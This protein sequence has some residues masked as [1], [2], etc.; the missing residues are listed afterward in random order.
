MQYE[1]SSRTGVAA[2]FAAVVLSI[3]MWMTGC[4]ATTPAERSAESAGAAPHGSNGAAVA[5]GA[6]APQT[7]STAAAAAAMEAYTEAIPGT[8][9][10]FDMVPV[11]AGQVTIQTDDGPRTVD[12]GPFWIEKTETTWDAF[13][14]YAFLDTA[15]VVEGE[16]IIRPSKPY[17]APDRGFGHRGYA[18]LSMSYGVAMTYAQWLSLKTGHTYRIPT[19]A[20]WEYACRAGALE[21]PG[22]DKAGL[23][24]RAWYWDNALDK[25]HPV[26][27]LKPNAWGI[28][29]MLGN[30]LEWCTRQDGDVE[31]MPVACGG[32]YNSKADRVS[33]SARL[34]QTPAWQETDP[35][36]PKSLFWLTDATFIGF[37]VIRVP[38]GQ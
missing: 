32:H 31:A 34:Q 29:D 11:P 21:D 30:A 22:A 1:S 14:V 13:D 15:E 27:S 19:E 6:G 8:L 36:I 25:T 12:V 26:A 33:C 4:A 17:G 37:R 9:V 23:A 35:Q 3:G 38:D 24:E 7:A 5:S 10:T 20:E 28:H 16:L 18:A 2:G